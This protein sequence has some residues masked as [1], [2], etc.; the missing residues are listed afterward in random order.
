M[1]Y[2]SRTGADR[3]LQKQAVANFDLNRY[4]VL[5]LDAP[6]TDGVLVPLTLLRAD[7]ARTAPWDRPAILF[8]YGAYGDLL[9]D[10]FS[11]ANLSLADRG[12]VVRPRPTRVAGGERGR[13]WFSRPR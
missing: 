4:E 13:S 5:R 2:N 11:P 10:D 7:A 8:G 9:L 3:L 12:F 6:S 1:A